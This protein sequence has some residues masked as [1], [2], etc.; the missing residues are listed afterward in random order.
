MF[1]LFDVQI[2]IIQGT[3]ARGPEGTFSF[4][5]RIIG[6][7]YAMQRDS[8]SFFGIING[9]S[10]YFTDYISFTLFGKRCIKLWTSNIFIIDTDHRLGN[11]T[12]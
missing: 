10:P 11:I 2:Q 3:E 1:H 9:W 5:I 8:E 7:G 12:I 4:K 6:A